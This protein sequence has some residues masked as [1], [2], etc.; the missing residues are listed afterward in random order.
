MSI[1]IIKKFYTKVVTS[2]LELTGGLNRFPR[3][4]NWCRW[5]ESNS[6][7]FAGTGF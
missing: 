3:D 4:L 1:I 2:S 6:H 7:S 5:R